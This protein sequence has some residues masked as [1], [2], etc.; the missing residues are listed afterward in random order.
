METC[1]MQQG[2][3]G[4]GDGL[5]NALRRKRNFTYRIRYPLRVSQQGGWLREVRSRMTALTDP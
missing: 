1:G 3:E 4:E 2:R 5:G